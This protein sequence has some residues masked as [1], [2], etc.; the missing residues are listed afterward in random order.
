LK[1]SN[2]KLRYI[3]IHGISREKVE[4]TL[5]EK[6]PLIPVCNGKPGLAKRD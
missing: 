5:V 3:Q 4:V 1:V 2:G 6:G